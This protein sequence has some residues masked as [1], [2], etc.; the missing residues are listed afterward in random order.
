MLKQNGVKFTGA[1]NDSDNTYITEV[2]L[3]NTVII[4]GNEGQGISGDFLTL[5]DEMITIPLTP[6]CE[7]LNIAAAASIIM[8]EA[9]T[10]RANGG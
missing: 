1:S 3:T 10:T 2:N 7:S 6:D 8:W 4:L 5:C 9:S